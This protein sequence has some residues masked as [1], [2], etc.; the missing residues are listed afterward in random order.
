[1]RSNKSLQTENLYH[2]RKAR[3]FNPRRLK[4]RPNVFSH[5]SRNVKK[6]RYQSAHE[7]RDFPY[8][9]P[10]EIQRFESHPYSENEYDEV[11]SFD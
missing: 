4:K 7:L 3:Q 10:A 6:V 11:N 8:P 5:N 9:P 1:M 2:R